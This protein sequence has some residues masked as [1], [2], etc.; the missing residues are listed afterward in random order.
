M[1]LIGKFLFKRSQN[2]LMRLDS[3]L[4]EVKSLSCHTSLMLILSWGF[5]SNSTL[6]IDNFLCCLKLLFNIFFF[7]FESLNVVNLIAAHYSSRVHFVV[8]GI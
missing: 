1:A 5:G 7:F 6:S 8:A 3:D 4:T 2:Y